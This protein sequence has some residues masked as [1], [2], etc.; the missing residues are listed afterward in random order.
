LSQLK[1][2]AAQTAQA[3]E[4]IALRINDVQ[5]RTGEV[6]DAI[7]VI[8]ETSGVATTHAV[9][10][11]ASVAEQNTVMASISQ[12][13]GDAAASTAELSDTVHSL[14][15]A[16]GRTR[17]AAEEVQVASGVSAAA[18]EKFSSLVDHFLERV[19]AA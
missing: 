7:Q 17:N 2:L 4:D 8:D 19:R 13:L 5:R 14:A 15:D 12:S 6:V 16:V 3:T 18:A 1:S 10:I 11:N 9:T